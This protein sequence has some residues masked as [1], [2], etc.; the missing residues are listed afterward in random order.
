MGKL[1]GIRVIDLSQFLPGPMLTV[2]MADHGAEVIKVEP[3]AG[4]PAREQAPFATY[5]GARH[6]V[7]FANLNRGKQSVVLDL[8]SEAGK[9]SLRELVAGADVFVESFRPGVMARLGFDY[10]SVRAIRPD[11]VYC[12]ISAFGQDGALSHHP[13]HDMAVQALAGFLAVNDG[14]DG[15]PVVPGAPSADLAAGLTGLSAVLMALVGRERTGEGAY[16]DCAMF[17]SMLPWC[18][19]IAGS[20]IAGGPSPRSAQQR[21]LGGAAFYHVYA[22]ADGKHVVLGGRELKFARNLLGALEREDLYPLADAP[23]G[24][25]GELIAFLSETFA[26][27]TRGEWEE[28]FADKDVAFAPVLDFREAFDAPHVAER[29]LL[30]TGAAG[31]SFIAPAIRFAGEAWTPGRVPGLGDGGA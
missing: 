14:A 4:D 2:M 9:A 6:S 29:G 18:A 7:W 25:Q 10:E 21:S 16:I 12:S 1:S 26:T 17:D 23:A 28:W 11:I 30:V 19:H 31:G 24:E 8:K 5:D 20:A 15:T 27:R 3:A 22:T 13:A